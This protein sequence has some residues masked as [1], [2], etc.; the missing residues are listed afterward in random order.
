MKLSATLKNNRGGQKVTADDTRIQVDLRLGNKLI[1]TISLYNIISD[2]TGGYR[3]IWTD[4][5]S[6]FKS[7]THGL[8]VKELYK[9]KQQTD[10]CNFIS[11]DDSYCITHNKS[12]E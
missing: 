8:L 5:H 7:G 10:K 2:E 9:G 3:V 1:G 6:T 12:H 11:E 4:E